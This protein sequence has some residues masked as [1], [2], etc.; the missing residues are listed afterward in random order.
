MWDWFRENKDEYDSI[1]WI[2]NVAQC[3][4]WMLGYQSV[5]L[6]ACGKLFGRRIW[7]KGITSL[8]HVLKVMF[9][10]QP[11]LSFFLLSR[12]HEVNSFLCHT[13]LPWCD[14]P[15]PTL[16]MGAKWLWAEISETV[17][18]NKSLF[19][20]SWLPEIFCHSDGKL[21]QAGSPLEVLQT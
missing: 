14:P 8:G 11:L 4:G 7:W 2:L 17:T 21:T 18:S 10:S 19:L 5:A 1:V 3:L 15:H 13:L 9:G 16:K 20:I 12:H 6:L